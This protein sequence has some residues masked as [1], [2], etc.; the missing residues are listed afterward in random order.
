[1]K[2]TLPS[3]TVVPTSLDAMSLISS[4]RPASL[5]EDRY[6]FKSNFISR[7]VRLALEWPSQDGVVIGLFGSWG[8]G[9]TTILNMFREH[10]VR[11]KAI[12]QNVRVASF[13]PWF[14]EDTGALITSFF[15]TIAEELK[16]GDGKGLKTAGKAFK[17]MGAI[18]T[19][20]ATG[21]TAVARNVTIAGVKVDVEAISKSLK[22]GGELSGSLA[23]LAE[24]ADGGEK[25][26]HQH[27]ATVEKALKSLGKK[28]GRV[29][30]LVDDVDRLSKAELLT[31]L[32]L[33]RTVANLPF[34]TLVVAMD[35]ERVR[36][37]LKEAVS[38]GY[39]KGFLDKII[40]VPLHVPPPERN[41]MAKELVVRLKATFEAMGL[42]LPKE[43]TISQ[44]YEPEELNILLSLI[45]TPRDLA[46]Y[47]NGLR[48]LL[49]AGGAPD[50][51]L[52]DAALIEALRIFYPD[53]YD[54]IRR[55][56]QFLVGSSSSL[57]S[58][59][60][61]HM[62]SRDR[63][64]ERDR[65]SA[66][67]E[68]IVLGDADALGPKAEESVRTLLRLL[69]GN[70]ID[71]NSKRDHESDAAARRISSPEFFD[72]Y[73]FYA[74]PS[75]SVTRRE[76]ETLLAKIVGHVKVDS[77]G[78]DNRIAAELA[79]AFQGR[80]ESALDRMAADLGHGLK[81]IQSEELEWIC[82]GVLAVDQLSQDIVV[83]LLASALAAVTDIRRIL[84]NEETKI[85][86]S[87]DELSHKI[88]QYALGSARLSPADLFGLIEHAAKYWLRQ[89]HRQELAGAL[90]RRIDNDLRANILFKGQDAQ[91][92]ADTCKVARILIETLGDSSPLQLKEFQ[93]RLIE[94]VNSHPESLPLLLYQVAM[95]P[96]PD[97]VPVLIYAKR[98]REQVCESLRDVFGE[99]EQLRPAFEELQKG[100]ANVGK[101]SRLVEHFGKVLAPSNSV[102][103]SVS[104]TESPQS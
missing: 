71:P 102:A 56:K 9:K 16:T 47:I 70:V 79:I 5:E 7:L 76:I 96:S 36:D 99:Y 50:V 51:H 29:V 42:C 35:D 8:I 23:G 81:H 11:N 66:E 34:M 67:F 103:V 78:R 18:F 28:Q 26:L 100:K 45:R 31:M 101:Y 10:V 60:L 40:Q 17:G 89:G 15:A 58:A 77:D 2:S 75:G 57:V 6:G 43:F 14:Y 69:F 24:L 90:L 37:I 4:D 62:G 85:K 3:N 84:G 38:E 82:R 30:V 72:T 39:G 93:A 21:V 98:T 27:R 52:L 80:D 94:C 74:P 63:Q 32:R 59:I 97:N 48:T 86:K 53:V 54:R 20:A 61:D 41:A 65:R 91:E 88:L 13:N 33:I 95:E 46:R 92:M 12:H 68:R 55:H 83:K 73:F 22:K 104:T 25:K 19:A 87:A 1:M 44:I 64:A 49:L